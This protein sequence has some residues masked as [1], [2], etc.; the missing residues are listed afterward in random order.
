MPRPHAETAQGRAEDVAHRTSAERAALMERSVGALPGEGPS[1]LATARVLVVGCGGIGGVVAH[2][3]ARSGVGSLVLVDHDAYDPTNGNRQICCYAD[4]MGLPKAEVLADALRGM[5]GGPEVRALVVR[6]T[7]AS[8]GREV[9]EADF[10]VAAADDYAFSLALLDA[11]LDS[12]RPCAFALPIGSWAGVAVF[13]PGGPA[14]ARLFGKR[15][16]DEAGY[17]GAIAAGLTRF[18]R[19]ARRRGR[20]PATPGYDRYL[21]GALPPPQLCPVVW[22]A[23]SILALEALKLLAGLGRP[24]LAPRWQEV[25]LAGA[26]T[27][28][29]PLIGYSGFLARAGKD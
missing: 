7:T 15:R 9:D 5:S 16:E 29:S 20:G 26:R 12:G 2:E 3:L 22:T 24:I 23:A 18:A 14:P 10:V 19:A 28:R 25:T 4:S 17:R 21:D 11:A 6:G 27:R 8:L 13:A 1:R